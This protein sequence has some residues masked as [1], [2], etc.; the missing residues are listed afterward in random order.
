MANNLPRFLEGWRQN[1][2][3]WSQ[4]EGET[5]YPERMARN[6]LIEFIGGEPG[7]RLRDQFA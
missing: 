6:L 1:V 7:D 5:E 2:R 4:V 3:E